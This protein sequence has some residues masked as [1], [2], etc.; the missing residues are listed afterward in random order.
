MRIALAD[1]S[2]AML[3]GW[4]THLEAVPGCQVVLQAENGQQLLEGLPAVLPVHIVLLDMR[5]PVMDGF[6]T[7]RRLKERHT[8]VR[9]LASSCD[10]EDETILRAIHAG[11]HGFISKAARARDYALAVDHLM[12]TEYYHTDRVHQLLLKH[13]DGRTKQERARAQAYASITVR[14]WEVMEAVIDESEPNSEAIGGL[15]NMKKRTVETHCKNVCDALG[16]KTR[17]GA[18]VRLFRMGLLK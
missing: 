2:P 11:A 3:S 5:M 8:G 1:D 10:E 18:V 15:L 7:T 16:C 17:L 13:P 9:V 6:E 4:R 12:R 14:E